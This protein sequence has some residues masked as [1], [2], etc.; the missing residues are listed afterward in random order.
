MTYALLRVKEAA[1]IRGVSKATIYDLIKAGLFPHPVVMGPNSVAWPEYELTAINNA[2]VSGKSKEEIKALVVSLEAA[3][4]LA[5][6][7]LAS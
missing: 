2:V 3:R 1:R 6:V 4:N 5:S 7:S